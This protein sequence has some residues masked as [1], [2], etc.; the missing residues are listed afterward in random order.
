MQ[1]LK[2]TI[3]D[4]LE[5]RISANFFDPSKK[6]STQEIQ[7]LIR[8]ATSAPSAFNFQNWKFI[9]VHSV[10]AKD[11]LKSV[12]YGQQKIVDSAVTFV[13]CGTLHPY[14]SLAS[15][16]KPSL[17]AG[18]ISEKTYESWIKMAKASYESNPQFQ[19]DEA[20]RSASMA[21]MNL[22]IAA[23]SMGMVS[24][25]MIGFD[26]AGVTMEFKLTEN[27]IPAMLVAVGYPAPGNISQKPRLAVSQVLRIV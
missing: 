23:Q 7:E 17:Q 26:P 2:Q 6:I 11:R 13:V 10:E 18:L 12:A 15:T 20:I 4:L 5:K 24:G 8:L 14:T 22:M 9:A 21:A 27:E 1:N 16:L 3:T 19:R 25:P